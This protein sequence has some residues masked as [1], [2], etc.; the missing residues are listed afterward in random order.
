MQHLIVY[1]T[2]WRMSD[3]AAHETVIIRLPGLARV[4]RQ[5]GRK[6]G[7][8]AD[9]LD[10]PVDHSNMTRWCRGYTRIPEHRITE[11]AALLG[12]SAEEIR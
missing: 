8:V 6:M 1:A 7:W 2:L 11:L 4:L 5:Q 9:N 10:P 12:V 3:T